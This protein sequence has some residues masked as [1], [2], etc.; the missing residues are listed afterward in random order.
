MNNI[1]KPLKN[2]ILII[3]K[4][5]DKFI[6]TPISTLIY[7]INSKIGKENK[8]E[9]LLNLPNVLLYVSLFFAV[10]LFYFVDIKAYYNTSKV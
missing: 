1:F 10:V 5:I 2:L 9:K 4:F 7:K 6:V 3:Y 8:L